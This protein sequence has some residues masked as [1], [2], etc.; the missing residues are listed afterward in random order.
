MSLQAPLLGA[1]GEQKTKESPP[2]DEKAYLKGIADLPDLTPLLEKQ[3]ILGEYVAWRDGYM[4]WR[5]GD[6]RGAQGENTLSDHHKRSAEFQT[7]YPTVKTYSFRRT[8]AFWGAVTTCEGCLLFLWIDL[9]TTYAIGTPEMLYELTK[10]PNLVGGFFFMAGIYLSWFELINMD[11]EKLNANKLHYFWVSIESVTDLGIDKASYVGAL[12]YLLGAVLYTISQVSDFWELTPGVHNVLID[13]PLIV[14]GLMFFLGGVCELKINK[15]FESAPTRLVWWVA[16]LNCYGGLTFWLSACPA[17]FPGKLATRFAVTGTITYLLAA[18]LSLLMWRGEQYGGAL[19][20]TLNRAAQDKVKP[21]PNANDQ[22][23]LEVK[24]DDSS[25]VEDALR[26]RLSLSGL[27]FLIVSVCISAFSVIACCMCLN[28]RKDYKDDPETFRQ[29]LNMF[30]T[31]IVNIIIVHM[32]LVLNSAIVTMPKK[33]DEPYRSL[34]IV[35]RVLS[36]IVFFN[37]VL[38]LWVQLEEAKYL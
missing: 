29:E 38:N 2:T 31:G 15:V 22:I 24:D 10:V 17:L 9:I 19:I 30:M 34:A 14:G 33:G 32:V 13:W 28:H 11:S 8:I 5:K 16:V 37:T 25:R 21:A 3:G 20:L 1:E 36:L 27:F 12:T 18:V 6:A 4:K 23:A 35:M 26:P 7:W